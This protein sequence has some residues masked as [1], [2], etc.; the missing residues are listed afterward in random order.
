[1]I[2]DSIRTRLHPTPSA[3]TPQP[4]AVSE[5]PPVETVRVS[6]SADYEKKKRFATDLGLLAAGDVPAMI[7]IGA[8]FGWLP[9][10]SPLLAPLNAFNAMTGALGI[11]S[12][13]S[14]VR[15]CVTN[16]NVPLKDKIVDV[17]HIGNDFI[18]TGASMVPLFVDV[19]GPLSV[20]GA[21]FMGG[22]LLGA[23]G[24]VAKLLWDR[25]RGGEQSAHADGDQPRKLILDRFERRMGQI[26][27]LAAS[28]G[29]HSL[30]TNGAAIAIPAALAGIMV[31]F[32]G[33]FG[34]VYGFTQI[35]KSK[36]LLGQLH[37]M[38]ARGVQKFNLPQPT[39]RGIETRKL[40]VD[41]AIKRVERQRWLG[42]GQT[43]ASA[44]LIAA[45]CF[46]S[47]ALLV[48]G[49]AASTVFGV[50]SMALQIHASRHQIHRAITHARHEIGEKIHA[51][52][53]K[54]ERAFRGD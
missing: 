16:P 51:V 15:D 5:Q 39:R 33:A 25:H 17:A 36:Q 2:L 29:S 54:I 13:I 18:N 20:A 53:E 7:S 44:T 24:D 31:S 30:L 10:P 41:T 27:M 49:I 40:N 19:P 48:A 22:Q 28:I 26:P 47:P 12:D 21:I 32:G 43:A 45:G 37:E 3:P 8:N 1:M 4:P 35:R 6:Q 38:K 34:V 23:A 11:A 50:A 42:I 52:E 9:I 14:V 46:T